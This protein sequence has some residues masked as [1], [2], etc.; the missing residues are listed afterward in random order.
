MKLI[1]KQIK[2]LLG[3]FAIAAFK[4]I[5]FTNWYEAAKQVDFKNH[6]LEYFPNFHTLPSN[7]VFLKRCIHYY[8]MLPVLLFIVTIFY[9]SKKL[10]YR[11]T[12]WFAI[13]IPNWFRDLHT[14]KKKK[15]SELSF[16]AQRN[17]SHLYI[18]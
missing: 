4:S 17:P 8:Y 3:F 7:M 14:Q 9:I 6:L 18:L 1:L 13:R 2:Y 5:Y 12:L 16:S 15:N 11:K 10:L